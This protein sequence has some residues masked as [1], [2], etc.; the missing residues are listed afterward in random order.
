MTGQQL[1]EMNQIVGKL[2]SLITH[3]RYSGERLGT[4][5]PDAMEELMAQIQDASETLYMLRDETLRLEA[6]CSSK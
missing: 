3:E 6:A 2:G 4:V 1:Y 5:P